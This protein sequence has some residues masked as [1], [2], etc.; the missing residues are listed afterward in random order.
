MILPANTP[1]IV[2]FGAR[3]GALEADAQEDALQGGNQ[4]GSI[5]KENRGSFQP[6]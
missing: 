3:G 6:K 2:S 5:L 4:A 1:V